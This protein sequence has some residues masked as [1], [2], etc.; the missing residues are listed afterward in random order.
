MMV[1]FSPS[2]L[3][4]TLVAAADAPDPDPVPVIVVVV[5]VVVVVGNSLITTVILPLRK[6]RCCMLQGGRYHRTGLIK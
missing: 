1:S 2:V 4:R 6:R 3:S 5:V